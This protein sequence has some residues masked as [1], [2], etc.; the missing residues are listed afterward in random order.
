MPTGLTT[1]LKAKSR[2]HLISLLCAV[3]MRKLAGPGALNRF[4]TAFAAVLSPLGVPRPAWRASGGRKEQCGSTQK[5]DRKGLVQALEA[6]FR[7]RM[8]CSSVWTT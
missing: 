6:Q 3:G 1:A 8:S 4:R 7:T 2:E 5:S